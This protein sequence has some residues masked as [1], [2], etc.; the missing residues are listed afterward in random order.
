MLAQRR[1]DFGDPELAVGDVDVAPGDVGEFADAEAGRAENADRQAP[2]LRHVGEDRP[3]LTAGWRLHDLTLD[4]GEADRAVAC[5]V[6]FDTG[7]SRIRRSV[8]T[9]WRRVIGFSVLS[10]IQRLT[11]SAWIASGR[12]KPN[13]GSS[14]LRWTLSAACVPSDTSIRLAW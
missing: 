1:A 14:A 9:Y 5:R 12:I 10:L 3:H 2:P 8:P 6:R 7:W 4:A 11:S 13:V